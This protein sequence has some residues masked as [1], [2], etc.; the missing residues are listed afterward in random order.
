MKNEIQNKSEETKQK[1]PIQVVYKQPA[2]EP[3]RHKNTRN[4]KKNKNNIHLSIETFR[5]RSVN[6][7]EF[8]LLE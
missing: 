3:A 2:A 5:S 8:F 7:K 4:H 6:P 1:P